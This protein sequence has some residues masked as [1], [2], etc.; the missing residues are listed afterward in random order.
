MYL[1]CKS[2]FS[3]KYGTYSTE[4]LVKEGAEQNVSAMALTNINSTADAWTF[5]KLCNDHHIKPILGAEIRNGNTLLYILLAANDKGFQWINSFISDHLK[6]NKPFPLPSTAAAFYNSPQDGFVI[7]PLGAKPVEA[8]LSNQFIG[9]MPS[10]VNKLFLL[11]KSQLSKLVIRQPVTYQDEDHYY[12]HQLLRSINCNKVETK[13]PEEAK[14]GTRETFLPYSELIN[15]FAKYQVIIS[16]TMRLADACTIE[17]DLQLPKNRRYFTISVKDDAELL[18][19]LSMDG[20]KHRYN[21]SQKAMERVQ[22]ELAIIEEMGFTAYFLITWDIIRYAQ[23]RGFYHVGRGSGANSIV[24]YCLKITE[25]DPIELNLYFERFLN[26]ERTSPPDFDIDFSW[27]DRDEIIDYIFKRYGEQY[28]AL[29]G[30]YVTF[31]KRSVVRELAKVYGLPEPEIE[32]LSGLPFVTST[33]FTAWNKLKACAS[34]LDD[35][36]KGVVHYR[37]AGEVVNYTAIIKKLCSKYKLTAEDETAL[38]QSPFALGIIDDVFWKILYYAPFIH[39][40]PSNISIH[41]GGMIISEK[42]VHAY[43]VTFMPPKGFPTTQIDMHVAEDMALDKLDIL[44][45]RG[46]GHIKETVRLVK[47]NQ[48]IRI[49]IDDTVKFKK[50]P[51]I[52]KQL[53]NVDTIGCFYIESPAMRQ[54]LSK[55]RCDTY[56]ALVVASSIIRPGVASSGMMREYIARY[57]N[58][59]ETKY[60]HPVM[61]EILGETYGVMV[62][63]EDVMKVGHH[64]GG[65]SL[66]QADTLR[67]AMS[68]KYRNNNRFDLMKEQFFQNCGEKGYPPE[69]AAEVWRQMESFAGYSFCKAHSASFA[70]ESFQDLHLKRYYPIEFMVGVINN[71]G[72][73]YNTELYFIELRKAGGITHLPCVNRST[74]QTNIKGKDVYTGFVHIKDL[75]SSIAQGIAME[76]DRNGQYLGVQDF[77][78]RTSIDPEQL[79]ILISVG[80]FRFTGTSKKQLLWEANFLQKHRRA[81]V[82]CYPLF[83]EKPVEFQLPP[84]V[85]DAVDDMYDEQEILGFRMGNPF[86]LMEA[87]T[88]K[89]ISAKE[90]PSQFGRIVDMLLYF[91]DYKVVPTANNT[92]MAFGAFLD[93]HMDWVDTVHFPPSFQQYPLKGRGFYHIRGKVVEDFGFHSVEV[94]YLQKLGYKKRTYA[95]L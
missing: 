14:A 34:S 26:P 22:K 92:N 57:L 25:V 56:E 64:F 21:N 82:P 13:L 2:Y 59:G 81:L 50:D 76:R 16:N 38:L 5:Y 29:V 19:K 8:L 44:S 42:P 77:I 46:L 32:H 73:F 33:A 17:M 53:R 94:S 71:F 69:L 15:A 45:Q 79:N 28:V 65:L 80:A 72:G 47:E 66:A 30:A 4:E 95:N 86:D 7:Y 70:V 88:I 84:L 75:Q 51:A 52:K 36:N 78:K 63:Q 40:F 49:D 68:G 18:R 24:A 43:A 58:P 9:V 3:L 67:R 54:L 93:Q 37:S 23:S 91:I 10:E 1:N 31:Q 20:L 6:N 61:E 11:P 74:Y 55:L 90:L 87:Q 83:Q 35:Y 62:F 39:K 41:S 12:V 60:L 27:L 89:G 48:G 85:D